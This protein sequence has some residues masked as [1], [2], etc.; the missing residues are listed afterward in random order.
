[1][2]HNIVIGENE[3]KDLGNIVW[4]DPIYGRTLWTIGIPDKTAEEYVYAY[5]CRYWGFH[6]LF[7]NLFPNGVDFK[8]GESK[9]SEDWFFV[10]MA[11]Q[12]AGHKEHYDGAFYFDGVTKKVKYDVSRATGGISMNVHAGWNLIVSAN[13]TRALD[14]SGVTLALHVGNGVAFSLSGREV[15]DAAMA[16]NINLTNRLDALAVSEAVLKQ[17]LAGTFSS[18]QISVRDE[19]PFGMNVNIHIGCGVENAGRY[20]NLYRYD[21]QTGRFAFTGAF[22][23]TEKGQAMFGLS[24][25]LSYY[26]WQDKIYICKIFIFLCN[27]SDCICIFAII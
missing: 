4:D 19:A 25:D 22:R 1:M 15:T 10:Q 26:I 18:R 13:V 6:L 23:I 8:I 20:A 9:E 16:E 7:N 24:I 21:A 2:Q 12:T 3:V 27:M 17:Q 14:D 5:P 11:S